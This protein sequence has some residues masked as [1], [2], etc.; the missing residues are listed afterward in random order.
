MTGFGF[1]LFLALVVYLI[2]K[3]DG[4]SK[5]WRVVKAG[6]I[7]ALIAVLFFAGY[8]YWMDRRAESQ[9]IDFSKYEGTD[10]G[11]LARKHGGTSVPDTLPANFQGWDKPNQSNLTPDQ[12]STN[13]ATK[14]MVPMFAPDGTLRDIPADRVNDAIAHGGHVA[15]WN[16]DRKGKWCLV[17][18]LPSGAT[19]DDCNS[20]ANRTA[21]P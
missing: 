2:D 6:G 11:A 16:R 21:N 3:N 14:E 8:S 15:V 1:F 17:P 19:L 12:V 7:V 13:N 5:L 10:Y 4:W 20:S 18:P 9:R